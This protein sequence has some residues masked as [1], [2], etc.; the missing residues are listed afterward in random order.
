MH[1]Y[2]ETPVSTTVHGQRGSPSFDN[3]VSP[4]APLVRSGTNAASP[5]DAAYWGSDRVRRAGSERQRQPA[6]E[7]LVRG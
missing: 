2:A 4:V 1:A 6:A 3:A 7:A 5:D